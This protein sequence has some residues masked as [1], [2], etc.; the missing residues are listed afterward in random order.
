MNHSPNKLALICS[1]IITYLVITIFCVYHWYSSDRIPWADVVILAVS[2]FII[3]F[4]VFKYT[5]ENFIYD[6]IKLIYKTIHNFKVSKEAKQ[7]KFTLDLKTD[8]LAEVNEQV[9]NWAQEQTNEIEQLKNL[10]KYRKE[11]LGNVSHEL[12]TPIFSMQGYIST[13]LDGGL[14]D[15]NIN[16]LYLERTEKNIERLTNIVNDLEAISRLES[17]ELKPEYG[18]FNIISLTDEVIDSLEVK[19]LNRKITLQFGGIYESPVNVYADREKIRQV[20][21]NL[22]QN[23]IAYG[24]EKGFTKISFFDMDE[25][26]LIEVTDN[27]IG[28]EKEHLSRIFE[29]FYRTDKSRSREQGG[30]G[31]GLA[32]VKHII[33]A[34]KQNISTRSTIGVGTTFSFTL[35]KT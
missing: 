13:L 21:T 29:R 32:I 31:L 28:I 30:T 19:A 23:S 15:Q 4:L 33:E 10:E 6:K 24:N 3:T 12:K 14:E 9:T 16:R 22:L 20:L 34:H 18:K 35:K 27:G 5:I 8:V 1:F 26:V 11:F 2:I 25:H 17:G 7:D